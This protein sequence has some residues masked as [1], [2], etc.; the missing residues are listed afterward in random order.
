MHPEEEALVAAIADAPAD[1]APR[2]VYADWLEEHGDVVRA[3]FIR[4]KILGPSGLG[5]FGSTNELLDSGFDFKGLRD[6]ALAAFARAAP[7]GCGHLFTD[8]GCY[9]RG[10]V[11]AASGDGLALA[12]ALDALLRTTPIRSLVVE[13]NADALLDCPALGRLRALT[14]SYDNWRDYPARL[15]NRLI[16]CP[17]LGRLEGLR[18]DTV[19]TYY[20][21]DSKWTDIEETQHHDRLTTAE[22]ERLLAHFGPR[23]RDGR[24][25]NPQQ[26][27]TPRR[28]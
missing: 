21:E 1:D 18:L 7:R 10:F 15:V 9:S 5:L 11:T 23:L 4:W 22:W 13:R 2:L 14:L 28:D 3:R 25:T 24:P 17:H 26:P 20:E 8:I 19:W 6:E 12:P 27:Y 16:A